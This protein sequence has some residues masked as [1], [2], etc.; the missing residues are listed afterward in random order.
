MSMKTVLLLMKGP[1]SGKNVRCCVV[2][3]FM[4]MAVL[5]FF[6]GSI[7]AT[8]SAALVVPSSPDLEKERRVIKF[9]EIYDKSGSNSVESFTFSCGRSDGVG[10]TVYYTV[11][12]EDGLPKFR[13]GSF[14]PLFS[15]EKETSVFVYDY[16]RPY[17]DSR[18]PLGNVYGLGADRE[19]KS[20]SKPSDVARSA[21]AAIELNEFDRTHDNLCKKRAYLW[22]RTVGASAG[23][24]RIAEKASDK[25]LIDLKNAN[26]NVTSQEITDFLDEYVEA[27]KNRVHPLATAGARQNSNGLI[28]GK[29]PPPINP[30]T[31]ERTRPEHLS[32][33]PPPIVPN[34]P[35]PEPLDRSKFTTE[36]ENNIHSTQWGFKIT[37]KYPYQMNGVV[38][39]YTGAQT[40]DYNFSVPASGTER[41][42]VRADPAQQMTAWIIS[43]S[44]AK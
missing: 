5:L 22:L 30:Q 34:S 26:I 44:R 21:M 8:V 14:N 7:A 28:R 15:S 31:T 32:P 20:V 19:N 4:C 6:F 17:L 41:I 13:K 12:F 9:D 38:R 18:L 37:S 10:Q 27:E 29:L 40:S 3:R 23:A 25:I 1:I 16:I 33:P 36:F 2:R 39:I 42:I 43:A 11:S 35:A 24:A